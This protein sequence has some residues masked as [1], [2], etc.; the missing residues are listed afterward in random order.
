MLRFHKAPPPQFEIGT[1]SDTTDPFTKSPL[2]GF[3]LCFF[4][5]LPRC[6]S[7]CAGCRCGGILA[8]GASTTLYFQS[9]PIGGPS[10]HLRR[11]I[12]P[13]L[14]IGGRPESPKCADNFHRVPPNLQ[15]PR[16][17][18]CFFISFFCTV[19]SAARNWWDIYQ[20]SGCE[21]LREQRLY[22][23]LRLPR[24]SSG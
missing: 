15:G 2:C 13:Q 6:C 16:R 4:F 12:A 22:R 19:A 18:C 23:H 21:P 8:L 3:R 9:C 14:S 10:L 11:I 24:A 17:L 20:I 7:P 1:K 5:F